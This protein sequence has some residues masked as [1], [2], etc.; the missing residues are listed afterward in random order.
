MTTAT[1]KKWGNS[2]AVRFTQ[3]MMRTLN[4]APDDQVEIIERPDS[5]E[6]TIRLSKRRPTYQEL[7]AQMTPENT[8]A[9]FDWGKPVGKEII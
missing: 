3:S 5:G 6:I 7:I 1:L 8:H 4:A 9:A 2:P